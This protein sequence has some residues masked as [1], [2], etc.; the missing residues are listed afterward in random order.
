MIQE[1]DPKIPA[2]YQGKL[3]VCFFKDE[4]THRCSALPLNDT[5]A[6]S[7]GNLNYASSMSKM[8]GRRLI[9]VIFNVNGSFASKARV[10]ATKIKHDASKPLKASDIK[11]S[12]I[13]Q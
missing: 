6:G 4:K 8:L 3:M 11:I 7:T 5:E 13:L 12:N 10:Y 9:I 1:D 2:E